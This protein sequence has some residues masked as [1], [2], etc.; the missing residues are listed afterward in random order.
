MDSV[1]PQQ[2]MR[3]ISYVIKQISQFMDGNI[4]GSTM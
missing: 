1:H 4:K 3:S 2:Q